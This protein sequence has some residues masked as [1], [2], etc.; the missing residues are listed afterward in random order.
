[1]P[2]QGETKPPK[3]QQKPA[4]KD[5]QKQPAAQDQKP[6]TL[7]PVIVTAF[8][9]PHDPFELPRSVTYVDQEDIVRRDKASILDTLNR[10][11][12]VWVEKRTES[13]SDPVIRGL[14][15]ANLLALVDGNPLTTFWGEGGFA[16]DDMYG[17]V[18]AEGIERIEVIRGPASVAYGS[19]ALG[20]VINFI[21]R[22]PTLEYPDEG[23]RV[24]GRFKSSYNTI[25][26]AELARFDFE[27]AV[28]KFRMRLGGTYRDLD[29][30]QG[31]DDIGTLDPSG[32]H[33]KNFDLNSELRVGP[34]DQTLL[35]SMQQVN[36]D[37]LARYYRPTQ[38]NENDRTGVTVGY[39]SSAPEAA[40]GWEGR[41][42]YQWKED[43]R[44]FDNG[45]F[46]VAKWRTM[47]TDWSVRSESLVPDHRL[48]AGFTLRK[49]NGESPDDEQFTIITP[50][51]VRTK[52]APD[53]KWWN[54][55]VFFEDEWDVAPW[56][57]LIGGVRY[58]RFLYESRPDENY[59]P[60]VGDPALD[61]LRDW[62]HSFTGGVGAVA[63][64]AEG[65]RL[66]ASWAKGFR[67]FAP[68]FGITQHAFGVIVPTG[69]LEPVTGD[70]YELALRCRNHAFES[71]LVGYYTDFDRFQNIVP[72]QFMGQD[73]YDY[74]G[75]GTFEPDER[76]YV[77]TGNGRAYVYGVE[78]EARVEPHHFWESVPE[79]VYVYGGFMWNYGNDVTNDEP[80]RHTHPARG[81]VTVGYEEP[82]SGKWYVEL[83]ADIVR[84]F[85]RIPSGRLQSDL[86]YKKEPQDSGSPLVRDDGLPGYT[87]FDLRGGVQLNE[88]LAF[89]MNIENLTN[90][91]YRPAHSRMDAFGF[92]V[93]VFLEA[94]F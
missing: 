38:R 54:L 80:L 34:E 42:Y 31:G 2:K 17:K 9:S 92:T 86:G 64:L 89:G 24:G 56:L 40:D 3:E 93:R 87:V 26:D 85:T 79:G 36:R 68:R 62:D 53:Q 4:P 48:L 5:Q 75:S 52:A 6:V 14:S 13:T 19:N 30:G 63:K 83:V 16:G 43:R 81:V 49:D 84:E 94:T 55:G 25:N 32:G 7:P 61:D 12:G 57:T 72:G 41:F 69:M 77:T 8:R 28:P 50:A 82:E 46:G 29:D 88:N 22:R 35:I 44:Y 45:D 74:D 67:S 39:R 58:D 71:N 33:D 51:G 10:S 18:E 21:T 73:F 78:W 65:W 90:K 76:V 66:A 15:G 91:H 60:P 47:S 20:G 37:H 23:V 27:V 59:N 1:M 70:N 11:I